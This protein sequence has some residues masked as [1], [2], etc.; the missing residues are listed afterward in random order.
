MTDITLQNNN[1]NGGVPIKMNGA[2]VTYA[3]K[4][5]T[6]TVPLATSF[7][8]S[9][10][11]VS[12]YENPRLVISGY[13]DTEN[14]PANG[15]TMPLLRDLAKVEYDGSEETSVYLNISVGSINKKYLIGAKSE[16]DW[17]TDQNIK[18]IIESFNIKMASS[19]SRYAYFWNYSINLVETK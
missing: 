10:T 14:I 4:P 7:D 1:I 3:F 2:E 13:I 15:I 9:E 11:Q 8:L 17:D 12:G 18:V 6:R 16:T 5:L 19:E